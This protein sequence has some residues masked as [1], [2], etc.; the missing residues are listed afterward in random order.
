VASFIEVLTSSWRKCVTLS[1]RYKLS[2]GLQMN[3]TELLL[4][5]MFPMMIVFFL[6]IRKGHKTTSEKHLLY[7]QNQRSY[8]I[9]IENSDIDGIKKY[10]KLLVHNQHISSK[11]AKRMFTETTELSKMHPELEPTVEMI[12]SKLNNLLYGPSM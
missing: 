2:T 12:K 10:A 9:S 1:K 5:L 11:F 6:I 7:L 4:I 3:S 8:N